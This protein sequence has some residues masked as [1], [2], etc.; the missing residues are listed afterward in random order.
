MG[1]KVALAALAGVLAGL[2]VWLGVARLGNPF[3]VAAGVV[4]VMSIPPPPPRWRC[5]R[6]RSI[7][8]SPRP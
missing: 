3:G 8:R 2:L 5:M 7:R 6:P 1:A 4:A